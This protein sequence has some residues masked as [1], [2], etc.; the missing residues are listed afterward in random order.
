MA[1]DLYDLHRWFGDDYRRNTRGRKTRADEIGVDEINVTDHVIMGEAVDGIRTA[2]SDRPSISVVR[3]FRHA[4]A[5]I[6]GATDA[7]ELTTKASLS[8]RP[9]FCWPSSATSTYCRVAGSSPALASV[10]RR[11]EYDAAGIPWEGSVTRVSRNSYVSVKLLW[12]SPAKPPARRL[13]QTRHA[14]ETLCA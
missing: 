8:S 4:L 1:V 10:G 5:A 6:A 12:R 2:R 13:I 14:C 7:R 11:P 3:P 9:P